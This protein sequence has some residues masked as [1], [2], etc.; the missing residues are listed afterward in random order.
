MGYGNERN[1]GEDNTP[2]LRHYTRVRHYP[3]NLI[4]KMT[5]GSE[6]YEYGSVKLK[7]EYMSKNTMEVGKKNTVDGVI[8][9]CKLQLSLK[10]GLNR[11]GKKVEE[12]AQKEIKQIHD[13]STF[14]PILDKYLSKE[15]RKIDLS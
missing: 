15:E 12:A 9:S 6:P 1:N 3:N 11:S 8:H 4:S 2:Y 13:I 14:N 10:S 7:V 5:G